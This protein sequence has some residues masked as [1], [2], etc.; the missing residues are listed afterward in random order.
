MN[1]QYVGKGSQQ[2]QIPGKE[3][4]IQRTPE[5]Q[6]KNLRENID[7]IGKIW[8]DKNVRKERSEEENC[9][10]DL[11]QENCLDGQI[12]GTTKNIGEGQKGIGGSRKENDQ[13]KEKWK[14]LQRKKKSRKKIQ[15]LENG[16]KKTTM[17]WAI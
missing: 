16:Q 14:Q 4:R 12:K 3:E 10:E 8:Q 9:Q 2:S 13:G 7:K 17:K 5:R 15:G 1:I 11:Q 6:S